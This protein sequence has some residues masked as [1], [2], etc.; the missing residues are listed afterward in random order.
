MN[1]LIADA[2]QAPASGVQPLTNLVMQK[3][4]GNPFFATQFLKA[5]HQDGLITFDRE[6]G[7]WQCDLMAVQ[8]AALTD[9][10][11]EFMA[12]QL[13]KLPMATQEQLKFAACIGAKFDLKTL[14]IV[15]EEEEIQV[16]STLWPALQEGLIVPESKIY[17]FYLDDEQC[18]I[19]DHQFLNAEIFEQVYYRFFHDRV[20]QAAYS[21]NS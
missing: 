15:S 10:V 17:K 5:L 7:H 9:D 16:A 20:Q 19:P 4:Q 14:T 11:V 13:R 12:L 1:H 21:P 18:P 3:T 6:V 8:D 2:F